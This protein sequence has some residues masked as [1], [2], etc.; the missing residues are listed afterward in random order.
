MSAGD[1][2]DP[3]P[4][5]ERAG[6]G[7]DASDYDDFPY[8]SLPIAYTYPATL[9]A[10][11]TLHGLDAPAAEPARVLELG[12]ASGGNLIPMAARFPCSRFVGIDLS[13]RQIADG[14]RRIAG[15]G[16]GNIELIEADL[17]NTG[18]AR[19]HFEY[20]IC[21][22]VFSWVPGHVQDAI[23][24]MIEASLADN[25]IAAVS[26]NVL[27]G[28]HLRSPV[29]DILCS[30]VGNRGTPRER[31]ERA[32]AVLET[33][34]SATAGGFAFGQIMRAEAARLLR[35]PGSY[36]LGEFLAEH[37]AP[38]SF[39]DFM[40]RAGRHGLGFLCEADLDADAREL[41]APGMR[42][43]IAELAVQEPMR[44]GALLDQYGGRPFRRSLLVKAGAARAIR[45]PTL[46]DLRHLHV[47]MRLERMAPAAGGTASFKDA[48]GRRL[49]TR[50]AAVAQALF[51]LAEAWPGT[52]PVTELAA[53]GEGTKVARVLMSLIQ[54]GR[55]EL[56]L[57]A[58]SVGREDASRPVAWPLA[59]AEAAFGLPSVTG[60]RHVAVHLTKMG[61][62]ITARLD[63]TMDRAAL[64]QWL[65][66]EIAADQGQFHET[67]EPASWSNEQELLAMA[68]RH[69]DETI[70]HLASG[71]V[72][73][74]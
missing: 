2:A 36:L 69:I 47:S 43:R 4:V 30:Q 28:W 62:A 63:G 59:R 53:G 55:A 22:G 40:E 20:V 18:S 48:R 65:A 64:A 66:G 60:L 71:S 11:A 17:A 29:R 42:G 21:H 19:G 54:E 35:M 74:A 39:G 49:G 24:R 12:C 68:R 14:R 73:L 72:L 16:L 32:R 27:P 10:L 23:L 5:A 41:L 61:R 7:G 56:S 13:S 70:A 37:N 6:P 51:R 8:L 52:L 31:V 57:L 1:P 45:A 38:C 44:A 67:G 9:G 33:L 46:A 34:R 58:L 50:C 3:S 25:G 15:L 26:Y